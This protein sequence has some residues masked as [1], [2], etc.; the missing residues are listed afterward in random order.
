MKTIGS[1]FSIESFVKT[2]IRIAQ[3]APPHTDHTEVTR[4]VV[5]AAPHPRAE[6]PACRGGRRPPWW[7]GPLVA[8]VS[9]RA[10]SS[11]QKAK[12]TPQRPE[13]VFKR[14]GQFP[15]RMSL[16][17]F[18]YSD[19]RNLP[20]SLFSLGNSFPQWTPREDHSFG[21]AFPPLCTAIWGKGDSYS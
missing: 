10:I 6:R 3:R 8:E 2:E 11:T 15:T 1:C 19:R 18:L 9:I 16:A 17:A 13:L 5:Q 14:L 20:S 12:P 4:A 7:P 21:P